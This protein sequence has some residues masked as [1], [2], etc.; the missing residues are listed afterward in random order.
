MQSGFCE[1]NRSDFQKWLRNVFIFAAP[2]VVLYL[3]FVSNEITK[4]GLQMIDF[5]PNT[6]VLGAMI[7]YVINTCMDFVKKYLK[8]NTQV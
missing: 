7:L 5:V 4:D 6:I 8:D 2:V 1:F 3:S